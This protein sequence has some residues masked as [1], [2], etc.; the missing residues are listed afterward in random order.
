MNHI[1]II[2]DRIQQEAKQS[3]YKT[4]LG[5]T[6]QP[7][8]KSLLTMATGSGKSRIPL[9]FMQENKFEKIALIVPT[10]KLRD[11]NWKDEF[12]A[13]DCSEYWNKTTRLCY[14]S[15]SKYSLHE[16]DL[17]ILDEAHRMTDL[18][19][20]FFLQNTIHNII[21]LTATPPQELEKIQIINQLG[22]QI[23]Y[24]LPLDKA[25][26]LGIVADYSIDV[27]YTQL[28]N[29]DKNIK[30]GSKTKPF[31]QTEKQSYDY[32]TKS[33]DYLVPSKRR[34]MLIFQRLRFLYDLPSKTLV[35][36]TLLE[37]LNMTRKKILVF[38]GSI[39][40]AETLSDTFYHSK[41][42]DTH[43]RAFMNDEIRLL[44]AVKA[45]NEG[46]TIPNLDIGIQVAFT[47]KD[48]DMT[49]QMGRVLRFR[50]G[51]KAKMIVIC[52]KNTQDEV[53]LEKAFNNLNKDKITYYD[54]IECYLEKFN[55]IFI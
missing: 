8:C 2:K 1:N 32:L 45:L 30:A 38:C 33:I 18:S 48:R 19:F 7:K 47:S 26:E 54:N 53:W 51:H 55:E 12:D 13:W 52:C 16:F 4:N 37:K 23:T 6:I 25:V 39:S 46:I 31:M 3:I 50:E 41:T 21:A 10:E 27:I 17:V 9:L 24:D 34:E 35:A 22:L 44:T 20:Q 42:K 5:S 40:Q 29:I 11:D 14:A 15:A 49:Q 36:Q 43:L 28:N